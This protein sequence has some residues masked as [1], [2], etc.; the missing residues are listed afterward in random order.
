MLVSTL[1]TSPFPELRPLEESREVPSLGEL[2]RSKTSLPIRTTPMEESPPAIAPRTAPATRPPLQVSR[3]PEAPDPSPSPRPAGGIL[4]E[5][6]LS[7]GDAPPLPPAIAAYMAEE[8]FTEPKAIQPFPLPTTLPH[9]P[10]TA[11]A[12]PDSPTDGPA[13]L[14]SGAPMPTPSTAAS[15]SP[16]LPDAE[17]PP[18]PGTDEELK[19][20][21]LPILEA[22]LSKA[23]YAPETGLHTYLEPMLRNTVRRAIAEQMETSHQFSSI[24]AA[25]RLAWRLSA[26]LTSRSYEEIVFDRTRRY[27]V[28]EVFLIRKTTHTLI[29]YA[30]HDPVRHASQRRIESTLKTLVSK[31][32]D[33]DGKLQTSFDLPE[34]RVALVRNGSHSLLLTVLRGRSNALVRADLDYIQRQAEERFGSRLEDETDT[35]IHVLQPILEGCLLIQSPAPPR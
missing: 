19:D 30:S 34:R 1:P 24:G 33:D 28:E 15:D 8:P 12:S 17:L 22:T 4:E 27:Q 2:L 3:F 6:P 5:M 9:P 11:P 10:P 16:P 26:L 7:A 31:I 18:E 32:D 21:L 20:A 14:D 23:L 13:P 29:S 25:D 35:F